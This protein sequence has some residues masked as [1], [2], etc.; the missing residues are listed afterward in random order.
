M[1]LLLSSHYFFKGA[2]L[3]QPHDAVLV[4]LS[5]DV[6]Q[7][8]CS[9]GRS[10][11]KIL[12]ASRHAEDIQAV[13]QDHPLNE[14]G[15]VHWGGPAHAED[16][17]LG[18]MEHGRYDVSLLVVGRG[19]RDREKADIIAGIMQPTRKLAPLCTGAAGDVAGAQDL[20]S[21]DVPLGAGGS[22]SACSTGCW[23]PGDSAD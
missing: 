6:I 16:V 11:H 9:L 18:C 10:F 7:V 14:I 20:V 4:G 2:H 3:D 21:V 5:F 22:V 17:E 23:G 8:R 19:V 12:V 15:P 1:L 13:F